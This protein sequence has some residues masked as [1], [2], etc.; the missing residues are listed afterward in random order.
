MTETDDFRLSFVWDSDEP[1]GGAATAAAGRAVLEVGG[2]VVWGRGRGLEA[3]GVH[4]HWHEFLGHLAVQ[5]V[6]L[7][8]EQD[9]PLNLSPDFPHLLRRSAEELW[10]TE[11][12]AGGLSEARYLDEEEAVFHFEGRH[13]LAAGIEGLKLPEVFIL[14]RNDGM[15]VSG[16]SFGPVVAPAGAVLRALEQAG[17]MIA[18]RLR[19]LA[20]PAAVA[21]LQAWETRNPPPTPY[22]IGIAIGASVDVVK[23]ITGDLPLAEAWGMPADAFQ[24]NEFLAAARMGT[25]AR[26]RPRSVRLIFEW[27]RSLPAPR[28]PQLDRVSR[29]AAGILALSTDEPHAQGRQLA[30]WLRGAERET[31]PSR[32]LEAWRV[33]VR[34]VSLDEPALDAMGCWGPSHGPAV[35]LNIDSDRNRRTSGRRAALAH[36]IC[37]LLVDRDGALPFAEIIDGRCRE[38]AEQRARAFAAEFLLPRSVI[39][40]REFPGDERVGDHVQALADEHDVSTEIAAWQVRRSRWGER[41]GERARRV[42]KGFVSRPDNMD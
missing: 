28:L 18:G 33:V 9:Y 12:R 36:E 3:V 27:F 16:G 22:R 31:E 17:D 13:N 42:L 37:H 14:R 29:G 30:V 21:G 5:W 25:A 7:R 39:E 32:L 10:E 15:I 6:F 35:L 1:L 40:A 23:E 26:L 20:D 19:G 24:E 38:V 2:D 8:H 11:R 4:W 41:L 34:E